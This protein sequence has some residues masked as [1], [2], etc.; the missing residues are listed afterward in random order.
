M[1]WSPC[2]PSGL[3]LAD[4]HG[5]SSGDKV[6]HAAKV[7][8]GRGCKAAATTKIFTAAGGD[9]AMHTTQK[10]RLAHLFSRLQAGDVA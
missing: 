10:D 1:S 5:L 8:Q 2:L 3:S 6:K 4:I 9:V 7:A